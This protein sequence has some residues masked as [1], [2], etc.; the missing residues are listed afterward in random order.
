M[1]ET[2]RLVLVAASVASLRA[3]LARDYARLAA[4]IGA[5][6]PDL[7]PPDLYD[8]DAV[9]WSL[10]A[11]EDGTSQPPWTTYYFRLRGAPRLLLGAGGFVR[12]PRPGDDSVE[13][14]YSILAEHRRRGYASEAVAGMVAC[15]FRERKIKRV[16]AHTYPNLIASIGVLTK[17]GFRLEGPG[18]EQGTV[19]YLRKR[20]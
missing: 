20:A 2:E 3:E 13:L 16:I 14:G 1:I 11:I 10:R 17:N 9:A 7:W 19:C 15:A 18:Q 4:L 12:A 6:K 8:D 5:E